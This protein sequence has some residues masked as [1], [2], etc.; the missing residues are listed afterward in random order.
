MATDVGMQEIVINSLT[1]KIK[2]YD[3]FDVLEDGDEVKTVK[4]V[5]LL[6]FIAFKTKV[7]VISYVFYPEDY[8]C[9]LALG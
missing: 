1:G 6:L 9:N 5:R 2:A 3:S 7:V 4:R 8:K